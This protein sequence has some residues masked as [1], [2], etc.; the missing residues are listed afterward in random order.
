MFISKAE[1]E[2]LL[3]RTE[4]LSAQVEALQAQIG[5]MA[6]YVIEQQPKKKQG[7]EWTPEQRAKQSEFM[8]QRMAKKKETA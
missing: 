6:K 2:L 7:R 3:F 8:R 4:Q 5:R 1:K